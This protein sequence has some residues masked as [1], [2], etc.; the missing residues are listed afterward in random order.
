[1]DTNKRHENYPNWIVLLSNLV[2]LGIVALGFLIFLRIHLLFALGYI[3]YFLFLEYRLIRHHCTDCYY[4]GR[5]CAFGHG[6]ISA[7]FF[8]QG[9]AAKFCNHSMTW[10]DII[11]DI[12]IS[13]LPVLA[14]I[15]LM[16][17]EFD[18]FILAATIGI[19]LLTT[20]G[21]SFIRGRLACRYC[22][23]RDLGCPA[24]ALFNKNKNESDGNKQ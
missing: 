9:N 7:V 18:Y 19:I 16:V 20:F 22:K 23:Q 15:I 14:G 13:L 2:S 8:K 24:E 4:F 21:N 11:L 12:L 17:I 1:M 6:R 3:L 5:T 10:K